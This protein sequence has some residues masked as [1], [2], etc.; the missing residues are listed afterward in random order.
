MNQERWTPFTDWSHKCTCMHWLLLRG[1]Y[2]IKA[3]E[4]ALIDMSMMT[5]KQP[6][7]RIIFVYG[8]VGKLYILP[9]FYNSYWS[10]LTLGIKFYG[11]EEVRVTKCDA[12]KIVAF[13][14]RM[15]FICLYGFSRIL[16]PFIGFSHSFA[17]WK[18]CW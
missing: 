15:G 9:P 12:N 3:W 11:T 7:R 8:N 5:K 1:W 2:V 18:F 17:F 6:K 16:V 14:S 10:W 13:L 4:D